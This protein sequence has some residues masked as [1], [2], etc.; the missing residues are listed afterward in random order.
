MLPVV[1]RSLCPGS[2]E[3][4]EERQDG[5]VCGLGKAET[6]HRAASFT[7]HKPPMV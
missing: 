1:L 5:L 2:G 7:K 3:N 6:Q 4:E